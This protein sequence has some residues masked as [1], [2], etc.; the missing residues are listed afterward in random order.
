MPI[1]MLTGDSAI[2]ESERVFR[3]IP[4][5]RD[6][7]QRLIEAADIM[8]GVQSGSFLGLH[9]LQEAMTRPDFPIYLAA[10]LDRELLPKY[11]S[12]DPLWKQFCATTSVRDFRPK[13][14]VDLLGG[15]ALLTRVGELQPYP[16][17]SVVDAAYSISAAKYG[18]KF[19]LSFEAIVNDDLG[20]FR[21]FP[22]R[23]AVAARDTEDYLAASLVASATGPNTALFRARTKADNPNPIS[24]VPD[25]KPLTIDNIGAAITLINNRR[26][27]DGRPILARTFI[28]MVPPALEILARSLLGAQDVRITD[29][30]G[31]VIVTTNPISAKITLLVNPWLSNI[32]VSAKSP[33]TWYLLPEPGASRAA[34]SLAFLRGH[35]NPE[36][37]VKN[38]TGT[39]V[40]GG[41]VDPT[42]GSFDDDSVAYRVRHIIGG[43]QLDPIGTY[44]STGS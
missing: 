33:A 17:R 42:E 36:L 1:E 38:D 7:N 23:L 5:P 4:R 26:D 32:D 20:D 43:A 41:A 14:F 31:N 35:E 9:R 10:I 24:N 29:A 15:Q 40:G 21:S 2:A 11:A 34:L 39:L 12:I 37:R 25:N 22:D 6:Y 19:G 18:A 44:A 27:I 3:A 13:T 8:A 16:E 30:A 28:L